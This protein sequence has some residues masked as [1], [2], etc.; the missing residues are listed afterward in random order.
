MQKSLRESGL[1]LAWLCIFYAWPAFAQTPPANPNYTLGSD[2][3]LAGCASTPTGPCHGSKLSANDTLVINAPIATPMTGNPAN[4]NAPV[5]YSIKNETGNDYF[6]PWNKPQEWT[7]FLNAIGAPYQLANAPYTGPF[8]ASGGW[9]S[10]Q[11]SGS[12]CAPQAIGHICPDGS[13]PV[14]NTQLGYRWEGTTG[15]DQGNWGAQGD[16]YGP[17][18]ASV[19]NGDPN[20]TYRVTYVCSNGGWVQTH[21]EGSC[22]PVAGQCGA[23]TPGITALPPSCAN[24]AASDY[25]SELCAPTSTF[26]Q[27]T[28]P[29]GAGAGSAWTWTCLGTPGQPPATCSSS[30][31]VDGQCGNAAGQ[32]QNW[33]NP[34]FSNLS[35]PPSDLCANGTTA[36]N[37]SA[38]PDLNIWDNPGT[39]YEPNLYHW[40]CSGI[41]GSNVTVQCSAPDGDGYCGSAN[42]TSGSTPPDPAVD[43]LCSI[44]T[45]SAVTYG[46]QSWPSIPQW[47][48]TCS[49]SASGPLSSNGHCHEND[50]SA[51]Q[52]GVCGWATINVSDSNTVPPS[53]YLCD[54]TFGAEPSI[55]ASAPVF[56][57][58]S[59]SGW[60]WTCQGANNGST[61]SCTEPYDPFPGVCGPAKANWDPVD[62]PPST[63][64]CSGG[65]PDIPFFAGFY[66]TWNCWSGSGVSAAC[67][68]QGS[69][70][71]GQCG[72]ANGVSSLTTPAANLCNVGP[73][74]AVSNSGGT[75]TWQCGPWPHYDYCSAP[76]GSAVAGS[77]G[78][79]NGTSTPSVPYM[80][81]CG[82]GTPTAVTDTGN[83][84]WIWQC[85]S[86]AGT[87]NCSAANTA[88]G[89]G[90][91]G[92][93][94]GT[95]IPDAPNVNLCASGAASPVTGNG[96]WSWTCIGEGANVGQNAN[97]SANI[98]LACS[99]SITVGGS[100]PV[101]G[102][103]VSPSN[104]S[105][106]GQASWLEVDA[107]SPSSAS[108]QLQ[109]N[110]PFYGAFSKTFTAA[111]APPGYC[112]PCYRNLQSVSN[113]QVVVEG[114]AGSCPAD[115]SLNSGNPVT[116]TPTNVT[117][118]P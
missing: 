50:I 19:L 115:P 10:A 66:W 27:F 109:W 36:G 111:T 24:P 86:A 68:D 91:C 28:N 11:I 114:T 92:A 69:Y 79:A 32:P 56:I 21:A 88:T 44:G 16:V 90:V 43:F 2:P 41:G 61:V 93:T 14:S 75:W 98:C 30:T 70:T 5:C 95:A 55:A 77:C 63:G 94:N 97:C 106:Q 65:T 116:Y 58:G 22:L 52:P 102:G 84:Q 3:N 85:T 42:N 110:D 72:A 99:G 7:A 108:V 101:T 59:P 74:S 67:N 18:Y 87:A 8:P 107:V 40:T 34:T 6:V 15:G 39:T 83:G 31:G 54:T 12:C 117:V 64:L 35:G 105:V 13:G 57:L 49:N 60:H 26:G 9:V 62:T 29:G 17:V 81:L 113:T 100:T 47:Q 103:T 46:W 25:C 53:S 89:P 23:G 82:S 96:P 104:C 33:S 45:P 1:M 71:V 37:I 73:A 80:G 51:P 112:P 118:T 38:T 20:Q 4:P 78:T 48:W 76:V